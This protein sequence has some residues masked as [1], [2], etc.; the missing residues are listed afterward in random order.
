LDS[1]SG[2]RDKTYTY[3]W[4][5]L[6]GG[7][8]PDSTLRNQ[9]GLAAGQYSVAVLDS[10]N[11]TAADTFDLVQPSEIRSLPEIS[12]STAGGYNVN[13]FGDKTG[14]IVLHPEGGDITKGPYQIRWQRGGTSFELHGL[15]AGDYVVTVKDGINCS[16]TDT[17]IIAQPGKLQIDSVQMSDHNGYEVSCFEGSDGIIRVFG[18]GGEGGY[19]YDWNANN[20]SLGR[21]TS[22]LDN[23]TTGPYQLNLTDANNC[24][25][26]W[27]G[28]LES[29]DQLQLRFENTNMNCTGIEKGTTRAMVA[30]GLSSYTYLWET[31][32]TIQEL[33]GLDTGKYGLTVT[34]RNLCQIRDTSVIVQNPP[35][36]ITIQVVDSISCH[37][38]IDGKLAALVT[39]GI[40]PFSYDWS[41]GDHVETVSGPG[42]NYSVTVT[43]ADQCTGTQY[44]VLDDP[45]KLSANV[46][47]N[48]PK[49]F[50]FSDGSVILGAAG[51]TP[52]Y[53]Y[54]WNDVL[55]DGTL[56]ENLTTGNYRLRITDSRECLFDTAIIIKEP[57]PLK[58]SFDEANSVSPFC[59]DWQNG[60]LAIRVTGGSPVFQFEWKDYPDE[61]DSV[62]NNVRENEYEVIVTDI[63]GCTTEGKFKLKAMNSSCLGIPTAF[64]PNYDFANDT[65]EINY[66][67]EDGGEANFHDIYPDGVIE[68]YDRL[69]SLV[70]RCTGGCAEPW[71]GDDLKGRP[72]PVDSYYFIILL[73]NGKDTPAIKGIV[74]IIK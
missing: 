12:Q 46:N 37:D 4:A 35:V 38:G 19:N 10:F 64:T 58:L 63:Q 74:T 59:P 3:R 15:G 50:S 67:N 62:L 39:S 26:T 11:C 51:G 60:A 1:I 8:K 36:Q 34:D 41:T 32:E 27:T 70:Y 21:D 22:Y 48:G 18:D 54:F 9:T 53:R 65:W 30:G 31:G 42:G 23:L 47:I 33:S 44:F 49:C 13:C 71:N 2:G 16:T 73:N 52:E 61:S 40:A 20:I 28:N 5:D 6:S 57:P 17:I 69:G 25:I 45:D 55:V 7:S 24:A 72:L 68:V 14:S 43:D 56:V 66:I 29:P